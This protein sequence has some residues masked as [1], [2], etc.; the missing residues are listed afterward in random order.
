MDGSGEQ[1][2]AAK[3]LFSG[4]MFASIPALSALDHPVYDIWVL[5]CLI[6]P[7]PKA[8]TDFEKSSSEN[9]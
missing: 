3:K 1:S 7:A 9:P 8:L 4:W 2:D 6:P 5:D